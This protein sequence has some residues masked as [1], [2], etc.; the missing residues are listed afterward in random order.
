MV[1]EK[2]PKITM[3]INPDKETC[4][5]CHLEPIENGMVLVIFQVPCE[6]IFI[7]DFYKDFCAVLHPERKEVES[8][9]LS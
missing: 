2:F 6:G 4:D 1:E 5:M 8:Y 3:T 7:P 9:P